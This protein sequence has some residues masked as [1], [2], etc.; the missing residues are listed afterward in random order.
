VASLISIAH[1]LTRITG[2]LVYVV[3]ELV[4]VL[5]SLRSSP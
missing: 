2:D 5:K 1:L 3:Q 4:G